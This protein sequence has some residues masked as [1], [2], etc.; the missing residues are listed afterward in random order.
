MVSEPRFKPAVDRL[1]P[2]NIEAEEAILGGILIDPEA[3]GRVT[4]SLI[5][6]AFYIGAHRTIYQ[7]ALSLQSRGLPTDLMGITSWLKDQDVLEKI[8][9]QRRLAQSDDHKA[10]CGRNRDN[11]A[12]TRSCANRAMNGGTAHGHS[13]GCQS[14][15]ANAQQS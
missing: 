12:H 7:A 14:P 9:G 13:Q 1:P 2:Q 6:E 8:G 5:P 3:I 10:D 11:R 15:S 4:E